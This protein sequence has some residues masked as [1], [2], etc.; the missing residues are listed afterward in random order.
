VR[1]TKNLE[2][3]NLVFIDNSTSM[4]IKDQVDR[5][6]IV[7]E[8]IRDFQSNDIFS[9]SKIFTFGSVI[10]PIDH[11]SITTIK[12]DQSTTNFSLL[13]S[14]E[15]YAGK[16]ISSIVIIS[17]GVLTEGSNPIYNFEK[18]GKP[19]FTICVGDTSTKKDI[20]VNNLVYNEYIYANIQTSIAAT[21]LNTN[22]GGQL[23][24]ISLLEEGKIIQDK[25][26]E[27]SRI[28]SQTVS[29]DYT[30]TSSGEKK[31]SVSAN[32]L[33]G[34]SNKKNNNQTAFINVLNNKIKVM[35]VSGSPTNDLSFI[36]NSIL[37]DTN[38]IVKSITQI[39]KDVYLEKSISVKD[40]EDS[41]IYFLLHFPNSETK[42]DLFSKIISE[43]TDKRKSFFFLLS[44]NVD[45][46]KL[47]FLNDEL[48]FVVGRTSGNSFYVQ[49]SILESQLRNPLIQNSSNNALTA[50]NDLPPVSMPDWE[51]KAKTESQ[52]IALSKIN[53]TNSSIPLILTKRLGSKRAI[54]ILANDI[55][56][57]K[58]LKAGSSYNLFDRFILNSVKWLNATDDKKQLN[59]RT[60]KKIYSQ[61]EQIEFYAEVY[62][63]SFNSV[64]DAEVDLKIKSGDEVSQIRLNPLGNGIYEGV[65]QTNKT[66]DFQYFG[67]AKLVDQFLGKDE[68]RFNIGDIDLELVNTNPDVDFLKLL[69]H[70][71]KGRYYYNNNYSELFSIISDIQKKSSKEKID[72]TEHN[73]W[74]LEWLLIL[75]LLLFTL[76]WFIRKREGML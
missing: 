29:F 30:P 57:W 43:I 40:V 54:A 24:K 34:E 15:D 70:Q 66:G 60:S 58:L 10:K 20:I 12:F 1:I 51:L 49:P 42:N 48:P 53:N 13:T 23:L 75:V 22:L 19:I 64:S 7:K 62:D 8:F 59:I 18:I 67:T 61:G 21:I 9:K 71:S 35:L 28:G 76:E 44:Q 65:Y 25:T 41:D 33:I 74:S 5:P 56:K 69:S 4:T 47:R 31:I 38:L 11:D 3:T 45:N 55:W 14:V 52:V 2:P 63:E 16:N 46:S 6:D 32:I 50:W 72:I 68:G 36:K 17:D 27:L 26:I 37:L 39:G 73:L